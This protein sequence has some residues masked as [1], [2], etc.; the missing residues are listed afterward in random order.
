[1]K[2]ENIFSRRNKTEATITEYDIQYFPQKLKIQI[3]HII[4]EL[5]E[6]QRGF[7]GRNFEYNTMRDIIKTLNHEY[8]IIIQNE[9]HLVKIFQE[10]NDIY[11][12]Y[13]FI[14][15]FFSK[16]ESLKVV[17]PK[18]SKKEEQIGNEIVKLLY[19]NTNAFIDEVIHELNLRLKENGVGFRYESGKIL[20]ISDEYSYSEII[21]PT[22]RLINKKM[23]EGANNE[24][25]IACEHYKYGRNKECLNECLKSLEST[26]KCICVKRKWKYD[27]KKDTSS[28]LIEICFEHKLIP[29]YL[30]SQFSS[31]K[32]LLSSGMPT[33]RNRESGHGQGKK[34][35][36]V[37]DYIAGYALNL[38]A[39]NILLLVNSEH[40]L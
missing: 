32:N 39:T 27:V 3:L 8:G 17:T 20:R 4:T 25:S 18:K 33:I 11:F 14:E 37:D 21:L 30:Q 1:M 2:I 9:D 10:T 12:I 34:I 23:Y 29:D 38:T 16:A 35:K 7:D 5:F 6:N 19:F 40:A 22:L 15:M 28:K 31:L 24:F 26:M 36:T 13:D